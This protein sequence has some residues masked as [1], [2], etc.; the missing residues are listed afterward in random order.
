VCGAHVAPC[1]LPRSA[2]TRRSFIRVRAIGANPDLLIRG[3]DG[4]TAEWL[5][6][7]LGRPG[8]E[9][10]SVERIGTGQMSRNY[11]A[12]FD[13]GDSVVVKLASDDENS[14]GTGV[15]MGAYLREV[16]F[17]NNLAGRLGDSVPACHLAVY[18]E[19]EGWFTL[20]LADVTGA[21]QGDQIEGCTPAEA[22][23]A[24]ATLARIHAPVLNDLAL[25]TADWLN[26]PNPLN[27]DLLLQL[28]P[29]FRERYADQ[30]S[31]EHAA[32]IDRF[33][34]SL[35]GWY[36]ERRP[37]LG[38]V[39][40]DYR[41]D[42]L[43]FAGGS[44]TTVD[45]QTV[46]WGS[47]MVDVAYFLGT[48]LTSEDRREHEEELVRGY[49]ERLAEQGV[50]G[51]DWAQCWDGYR[52]G[53]FWGIVINVAAAIVVERTERGDAMFTTVFKRL[54]Q[55]IIDLEALELLPPPNT[56][57]PIP[58][59]PELADEGLHQPGPEDLWNES[60]YFDGV[61]DDESLGVYARIGRLPNRDEC[62]YTACICGPDRPTIM[63]VATMRLPEPDDRTQVIAS[64]GLRAEQRCES[65]LQRFRVTLD[66]TGEAFT[67]PSAVLRGESGEPVPIGFDLIFET[68]GT[69]FAWRQATRYEIPCRVHG[70]VRVGEEVVEFAGPGQ[71]D[72]SWGSR[73]W[74]ASDWMWSG[75]HLEDG[76]HT[77]AVGVPQMPGFGVGYVQ[78][79]G[80]VSEITGVTAT[81][82][83]AGN[84]LISAATIVSGPDELELVVEPLAFGPIL[85]VAPDGRVSHF[86]RAMCRVSAADGRTGTGW[87]EWNRNQR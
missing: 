23:V 27:Q 42:N 31:D 50:R 53:C 36:A 51:F 33:L 22:E 8:L 55:Q 47:S 56:E 29:V 40:Y 65:P 74:W 78:K 46:G 79:G 37:P 82:E 81:E 24:L 77:H 63:L 39:H 11:R 35:D 20:V 34:P 30:V 32:A 45:W 6:D 4:I 2:L 84:G 7:V 5:A 60:Y 64:D 68:D 49:H 73:D 52:R 62:L 13:G 16:A 71:R 12:T 10:A 38:I 67:D 17:Y 80:E 41:L 54:T 58:L 76:T 69:P 25:S 70:T 19:A 66:G 26:Q 57:R 14:R 28:W 83:V 21:H 3:P 59:Q 72:H 9:L 48:G 1:F 43:L 15:S 86:P 85:L 75:L 61:A 18:D 87:V 44:C